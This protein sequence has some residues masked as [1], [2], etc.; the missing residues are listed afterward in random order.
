M[1]KM[2]TYDDVFEQ[3]D[4]EQK[5]DGFSETLGCHHEETIV[6]KGIKI[7][8]QCGLVLG[9]DHQPDKQR[10]YDT[11]SHRYSRKLQEEQ[12]IFKDVE[13]KGIS[14]AVVI[15]A[16]QL[17]QTIMNEDTTVLKRGLT[18]R[19]IV[20][21]CIFKACLIHRQPQTYLHIS[22]KLNI[23]RKRALKGMADVMMKLPKESPVFEVSVTPKTFI[24]SFMN[25]LGA[26]PEHIHEVNQMFDRLS[27]HEYIS[28][29]RP[30]SIASGMIYYWIKET[31]RNIPLKDFARIASLSDLTIDKQEKDIR[32]KIEKLTSKG[33][34]F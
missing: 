19:G 25:Q 18:R 1:C 23:P 15:T 28:R 29:P 16:N 34:W 22:Q 13:N 3:F 27:E 11:S 7:C 12:N 24:E 31:G 32:M 30:Q 2:S 9:R 10:S 17:F 21:S 6:D 5:E 4:T 14:N 26:K 8:N 33:L 20:A